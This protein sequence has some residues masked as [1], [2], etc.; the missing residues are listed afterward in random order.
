MTSALISQYSSG[1]NESI[2]A[3]R[4]ITIFVATDWTLP[5]ER[6]LRIF[7]QSKGLNSYPTNLSRILR[8]CCAL[9][10]FMLI[11]RGFLM[12]SCTAVLVISLNVILHFDS[13]SIFNTL[14]RC[15]AIASP[16]RS[17]SVASSISSASAA[18]SLRSL[19][20]FSFPFIVMYK[21]LK[22]FFTSTPRFPE[23]R[24]LI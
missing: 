12:A 20:T 17:G 22:L 8:A 2:S 16:S 7:F 15:H 11:A 23:G 5:A 1:L 18:M 6:P 13:G 3:S 19:T 9:A 4:S 24:S 21:G 14:A 10:R